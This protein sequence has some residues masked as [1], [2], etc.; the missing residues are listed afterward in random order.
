M[1]RPALRVH[2]GPPVLL[3][4]LRMGR[5]GDANRAR[6]RIAAAIT[7][8]LVPLRAGERGPAGL[9]RPHPADDGGRGVPRRRRP[10]RHPVS[11]ARSDGH[12]D[13]TAGAGPAAGG[14]E[15][16]PVTTAP[17]AAGAA[18]AVPPV[19]R[20]LKRERFGWYS[21][22]WAMSVFN[23]SVTTV[24]LAP[25]LTAIA[26]GR[27]RPRRAAV[28]L[29]LS[30]SPPGSCFGYVLSVS[31]AAAGARAA[32]DRRVADRSGRKRQMLAGFAFLGSLRTMALFFV[33]DER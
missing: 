20:A 4:D 30:A 1:R 28:A 23:T 27:R 22:D 5:V 24:F 21:Y 10:R 33:A 7:R 31:V 29:G 26:R 18:P 2:V 15:P 12:A 16:A 13:R 3:D 32:A 11:S 6:Y 9:R 19:D 8:G 17:P 14:W 25:Y